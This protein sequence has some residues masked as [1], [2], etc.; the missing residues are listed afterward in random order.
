MIAGTYLISAAV[1][2]F[3]GYLFWIGALN[4]ITQTVL[5][6]VVFF[7]ASAAASS[8]YLTVSE[9]F[10]LELRGQAISFFFAISQL[11]G[12]VVA[13]WLFGRLVGDGTKPTPLFIGYLIGAGLMALGGLVAAFLGVDAERRSLEDIASPLTAVRTRASE[14]ADKFR[15]RFGPNG[16]ALAPPV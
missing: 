14:A 12:G 8:G 9:I 3:S 11:T 7:F 2:A 13:P 15:D 4:A 5:W 16:E 10:P 6:C 1:L